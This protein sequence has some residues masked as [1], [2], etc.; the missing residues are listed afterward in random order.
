MAQNTLKQNVETAA[1]II[2]EV[3][4]AIQ[5]KG[6]EIPEGTHATAYPGYIAKM[7]SQTEL[8]EFKEQ[9]VLN[10]TNHSEVQVS[11]PVIELNATDGNIN[12]N[13]ATGEAQYKGV[14]IATVEN[15]S[16]VSNQVIILDDTINTIHTKV[17]QNETDI[18]DLQTSVNTNTENISA[19]NNQ[20][21]LL[22]S[23]IENTD[24]RLS[25]AEQNITTNTQDISDLDDQINI[26]AKD[27][28]NYLPLSGGTMKGTLTMNAN[29]IILGTASRIYVNETDGVR[30]VSEN[31]RGLH[32]KATAPGANLHVTTNEG[33][34]YYNNNEIATKND[35]TTATSNYLPLTGGIMQGNLALNT[36]SLVFSGEV[37]TGTVKA[38]YSTD[39]SSHTSGGLRIEGADYPSS[40]ANI[41]IE[42]RQSGNIALKTDKGIATYN[43]SEIATIDNIPETSDLVDL[44]NNQTLAS[45][46]NLYFGGSDYNR[47]ANNGNIYATNLYT[48][49][50][51]KTTSNDG[52]MGVAII[53]TNPYVNIT[54][55][56]TGSDHGRV[57]YFFQGATTPTYQLM[58]GSSGV[59]SAVGNQ[60]YTGPSVSRELSSHNGVNNR[61]HVEGQSCLKGN[62]YSGGTQLIVSNAGKINNDDGLNGIQLYSDDDHAFVNI[63]TASGSSHSPQVRFYRDG[64]TAYPTSTLAETYPGILSI[65]NKL[66]VGTSKTTSSNNALSVTGTSSYTGNLYAQS[67]IYVGENKT[68]ATD[69]ISG[70]VISW[71]SIELS[72]GT[73]LIDFHYNNSTND[74]TSRIIEAYAGVLS[75][76][77]KLSIGS[78]TGTD[79]EYSLRVTGSTLLSGSIQLGQ[80]PLYLSGTTDG[81]LLRYT[82]STGLVLSNSRPTNI[83]ISHTGSGNIALTTNT[84]KATYNDKEIATT[85]DISALRNEIAE[86]KQQ[87]AELTAKL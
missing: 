75:I 87:I 25:T 68:S 29:P 13:P 26:I 83:A 59:L 8:E 20:V 22:N 43:G 10:G 55:A 61:L 17:S 72:A 7:T 2:K 76:P 80:Y 47:L 9:V 38:Y 45:T 57:R 46:K 58:E 40:I 69:D 30:V 11:A 23:D 74:Y 77:K 39:T 42:T 70:T 71:G 86:L 51:G 67:S 78:V 31:I 66:S 34:A 14:K 4:E 28:S 52:V 12:P 44:T 49:N 60:L 21:N 85:D 5:E 24:S 62:V 56:A 54:S 82:D 48:S 32:L 63:T 18:A 73:P 27:Q 15:V 36:N 84:G 3:K 81:V 35:I 37:N 16:G 64:A 65:P 41:A 6:V 1:E 19:L 33:I 53:G 50:V 79:S